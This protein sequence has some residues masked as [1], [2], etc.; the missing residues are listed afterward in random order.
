MGQL[1]YGVLNVQG[2]GFLST[3]PILILF[4]VC[5]IFRSYNHLQAEIYTLEINSTD[6]GSVVFRILVN[7]VD[8]GDRFLVTVDVVAVAELT[9]LCCVCSWSGLF[10]VQLMFLI[11]VVSWTQLVQGYGCVLCCQMC[12]KKVLNV[13]IK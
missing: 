5:C 9:I 7:L 4:F 1:L 10:V 8:N 2:E 12:F 6:N 13:L 11:R 3:Q